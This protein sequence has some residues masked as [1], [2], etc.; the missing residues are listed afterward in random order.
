[1]NN[2][3][4]KALIFDVDGT[5]YEPIPALTEILHKYWIKRIS[6][7]KR[8]PPQ[9][10]ETLFR[11]L[12][13]QYKSSTRVIESLGIESTF[14]IL[15]QAESY[16]ANHIR[17]Y[18]KP[19]R[20]MLQLIKKLRARFPLYTLRNGSRAGTKFVLGK[21]GF[22]NKRGARKGFGP[23]ED[24]L[25]TGELG[26]TK[27]HPDVFKNA[28]KILALH[29]NEVVMVG[30]RID[31][32]LIPAKKAG[33]KTVWISWGRENPKAPEVDV[34]IDTIYDMEELL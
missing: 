3:S 30:D 26:L 28:L 15:T 19:D 27:P 33:M 12:K 14:E 16:T 32:D 29:P 11:N 5:L 34:V 31:V 1:M 23:F 22:E 4:I 24:I 10:A 20:K 21:L 6:D 2:T 13:S 8:I 17:E 7:F 18:I 25:P 9:E